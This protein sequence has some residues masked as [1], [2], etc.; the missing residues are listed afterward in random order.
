MLSIR[1]MVFGFVM[2][3][4][5]PL[6][7]RQNLLVVPFS[8]DSQVKE[9]DR[10]LGLAVAQAL[11][12]PF[13][14]SADVGVVFR[15]SQIEV[16]KTL[17]VNWKKG[18]DKKTVQ[19]LGE[20][21]GSDLLVFGTY[22]VVGE[23]VVFNMS[24]LTYDGNHKGTVEAKAP[25]TEP[26]SA[27]A[28]LIE[29]LKDTLG[30]QA[31]PTH[32]G[33]ET[34]KIV[35]HKNFT[36]CYEKL[37]TVLERAAIKQ[38]KVVPDKSVL[39]ICA[40]AFE[41]DESFI[42]AQAT[43]LAANTLRGLD[44]AVQAS[45]AFLLKY[46]GHDIV[47]MALVAALNKVD[48][49]NDAD[50]YL[51]S[52]LK[53]NASSSLLLRQQAQLYFSW[54]DFD[55]AADLYLKNIQ[56]SPRNPFFHY[57]ASYCYYMRNKVTQ[58]LHHAK[59]ASELSKGSSAVYE[60]NLAERLLD[61]G[62]FEEARDRLVKVVEELAQQWVKPRVRLSYAFLNL[63]KADEALKQLTTARQLRLTSAE[64]KARI[65]VLMELNTAAAWGIKPN[66]RKA[67]QV[68][69]GLKKRGV[70]API[71][72]KTNAKFFEKIKDTPVYKSFEASMK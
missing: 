37:A 59:K 27:Y 69:K 43:M 64:R 23:E 34:R 25:L 50:K 51:A 3:A 21:V 22:A 47:S 58:A 65:D 62:R 41:H 24:M 4:S 30:L 17:G 12:L 7:A 48:K 10:W 70:L 9:A 6:M 49:E 46:P 57:R 15:G 29:K 56:L 20:L 53:H 19:R 28:R 2:L 32:E 40:A 71:D 11:G 18:L 54:D 63:G 66:A 52:A 42:L 72:L 1:T 14:N 36:I 44:N 26:F 35:A 39:R 8:P 31:L 61:A 38:K 5:V 45:Q 16:G 60:N 55:T 68:L 67:V 33:E 13:R